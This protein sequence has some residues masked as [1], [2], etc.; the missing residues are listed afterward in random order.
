MLR[1]AINR[2]MPPLVRSC[3]TSSEAQ[4][5]RFEKCVNKVTLVGRAGRGAEEKG[6]ESGRP[7]V[8]FTLAT[9][10]VYKDNRTDHEGEY[11]EKTQ[12]HRISV[13][14]S[15]ALRETVLKYV[16]KG[17]RLYITGKLEYSEYINR[18]G[19]KVFSTNIVADDVIFLS[20]RSSEDDQIEDDDDDDDDDDEH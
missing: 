14:Y 18:D 13:F 16:K 8:Q 19:G 2:L 12:W 17:S 9:S 15:P 10:D 4:I 5:R 1:S 6:L 7:V 11:R 20:T 3:T